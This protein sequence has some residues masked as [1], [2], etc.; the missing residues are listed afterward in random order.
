M[1]VASL[2]NLEGQPMEELPLKLQ[3]PPDQESVVGPEAAHGVEAATRTAP[4]AACEETA[5]EVE[6]APGVEEAPE[7]GGARRHPLPLSCPSPWDKGCQQQRRFFR[8]PVE[9]LCH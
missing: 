8:K 2:E 9:D 1:V 7:D 5:L 4:R 3:Q 6:A